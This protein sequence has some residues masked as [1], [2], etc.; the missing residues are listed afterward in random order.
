MCMQ[1]THTCYT[2]AYL[3][4]RSVY[5]DCHLL[6]TIKERKVQSNINNRLWKAF[7]N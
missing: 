3:H 4:V 2:C 1:M 5:M 7:N 6:K